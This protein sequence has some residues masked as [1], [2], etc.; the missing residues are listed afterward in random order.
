M[1]HREKTPT[2]EEEFGQLVVNAWTWAFLSSFACMALA[3]A[4][5]FN[6]SFFQD[7]PD[8]L[9]PLKEFFPLILGWS[10]WLMSCVGI[11]WYCVRRARRR[12]LKKHEFRHV[13]LADRGFLLISA[14]LALI[15]EQDATRIIATFILSW[16]LV[17]TLLHLAIAVG[18]GVKLP[19]R[20][21]LYPVGIIFFIALTWIL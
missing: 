17:F 11:V 2:P 15:M 8:D 3:M 12:G 13:E 10:I 19:W 21:W 16:L 5:Y 20:A 7:P 1:R 4:L 14:V 6:I 9:E 18:A